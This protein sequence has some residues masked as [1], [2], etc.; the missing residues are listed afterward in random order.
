MLKIWIILLL[1]F[2][3]FKIFSQAFYDYSNF[4]FHLRMQSRFSIFDTYRQN[5]LDN[6]STVNFA[7]TYRY[8]N[9]FGN[10]LFRAASPADPYT[11]NSPN[12]P[13]TTNGSQN[14]LTIRSAYIGF[15]IFNLN[16]L[17]LSFLMGRQ[18]TTGIKLYTP[19]AFDNVL[20]TNLN[21]RS[22][23]TGADGLAMRFLAD[24]SET[25]IFLDSGIYNTIPIAVYRTGSTW[26][27]TPII[28][29]SADL[30][31]TSEPHTQSRGYLFSLG[32][33]HKIN[34][35]CKI[36]FRSLYGTQKE[37][38]TKATNVNSYTARDVAN[39]E[40]SLSANYKSNLLAG[41]I[42]YQSIYIGQTKTG[43]K[44]STNQV[45]YITQT[46][47][48]SQTINTIGLG[49]II[50]SNFFEI[51]NFLIDNDSF[52]LTTA[53]QNIY[54]QLVSGGGGTTGVNT[55]TNQPLNS[56]LYSL[57]VGY[58]QNLFTIEVDY[59]TS[60]ANYEVYTDKSGIQNQKNAS[61]VY[62]VG[63]LSF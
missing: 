16:S 53:F 43:T 27:F 26:F 19:D 55:F 31:F 52:Y 62:L 32:A 37:S 1:L 60:M 38:V 56:N 3:H 5:Q 9:I 61:L 45:N 13:S 58:K 28:I 40:T 18:R 11:A 21:S 10:F 20:A 42:W 34:D 4:K 15:E 7:M 17:K 59:V 46:I 44:S 51:N 14:L 33:D 8:Q 6:I 54:G 2:S 63:T 41:G 49:I 22:N 12:S 23:I 48:D 35:G 39:L 29:N 30:A 36:E 25:N 47:D 50:D 57:A 24:F